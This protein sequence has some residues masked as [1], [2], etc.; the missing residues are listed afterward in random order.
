MSERG[1][2]VAADP[3]ERLLRAVVEQPAALIPHFHLSSDTPDHVDYGCVAD[4]AR[5]VEAVAA[6]WRGPHRVSR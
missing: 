3:D 1:A 4:A 6:R 2:A 5:L